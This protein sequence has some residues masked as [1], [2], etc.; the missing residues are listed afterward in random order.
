[1][2]LARPRVAVGCALL[3]TLGIVVAP[4]AATTAQAAPQPPN[5]L[6]I[7]SDDQPSEMFTPTFMP[8]V[9]SQIVNQGVR[10]DRGYDNSSVC[11]PSR[12]EIFTGLW[13]HHSGVDENDVGLDRPTI[14]MALHDQGY[15]TALTGKYLNSW[16]TCGPRAEFDEWACVASGKSD[17]SLVNPWINDNGAWSQVTGYQPDLLADRMIQFLNTTPASQPFFGVYAPTTP[18]LPANG[19]K[20]PAFQ[21][22]PARAPS[23]DEE[24]RTPDHPVWERSFPLTASDKTAFDN[25]H[26]QMG[27]ATRALDDSVSRILAALGSRAADTVVIFISDNGY[28]YGEHRRT[29]K[30][31]PFEESVRVPMA[32]RFPSVVAPGSAFATEALVGNVDITPTIADAVGFPWHADGTSLLP[33]LDGSASTVRDAYLLERC[34][35]IKFLTDPCRSHAWYPPRQTTNPTYQAVVTHRYKLIRY[36]LTGESQLFGLAND[37]YELDNLTADPSMASVKSTLQDQLDALLAPPPIDTTIVTGPSG[38]VRSRDA[39]FQ[40][41]SASRTAQYRCRL[42]HDGVAG[43]W[44]ACDGQRTTVGG[45]EDGDYTFEV[46]GIDETGATDPTPASRDFSIASTGPAVHLTTEPP[47]AQR[48]RSVAYGF[49]SP[50]AG[51]AFECRLRQLGTPAPDWS[52]CDPGTGISFSNL[53]DGLWSFEVRAH[54]PGTGDVTD[55]PAASLVRIDNAGPSW[56]LGARPPTSTDQTTAAFTFAP[57]EGLGGPISCRLGTKP[58]VDCSSGT[59]SLT[60]L[61]DGGHTLSIT[62]TDE[63]G[64]AATTKLTWQVDRTPPTVAISSK[65]SNPSTSTTPTFSFS[66]AGAAMYL[67]TLDA[68]T[69]TPC[70]A[71]QSMGTLTPGTHTLTVRSLDKPGNLSAPVSYTWTITG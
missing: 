31:S 5:V 6:L 18:H 43:S 52:S 46:A 64:N 15:R 34:T 4:V 28:H 44:F 40:Y 71:T 42:I 69:S 35:G 39:T 38:P 59:L 12:A 49:D 9:F 36:P 32:I 27:R 8:A 7:I 57:T 24:T 14:A 11:C 50:V 2:R 3:V 21:V 60:G 33:I 13:E 65:P 66:G 19:G 48:S 68:W 54:D 45:L 26:R 20:Y 16:K 10:F 25:Q 1:M 30:A 47:D 23:Y 67:C 62:A 41:F 70:K 29:W 63:L 17:Y 51:A 37:P 61:S 53:A 58:A 55:P 56:V 22:P